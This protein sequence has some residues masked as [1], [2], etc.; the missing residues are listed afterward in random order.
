[1]I[2]T[3][4]RMGRLLG[5]LLLGI[6]ALLQAHQAQAAH[7]IRGITGPDFNLYAYPFNMSLPEGT[8]LY[9]WGFGDLSGQAE[10]LCPA[11]V[12]GADPD[13]QRGRRCHDHSDQLRRAR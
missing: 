6:G 2:N 11:A 4:N 7:D 8:S 3:R 5:T 13:R 12:P 9:M 1:M 10:W